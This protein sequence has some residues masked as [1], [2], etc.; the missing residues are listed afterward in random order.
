MLLVIENRKTTNRN[1][2]WSAS[3]LVLVAALVA[4]PFWDT[5]TVGQN[6]WQNPVTPFDV[7]DDTF[8]TPDDF[9]VESNA[10]RAG[11]ILTLPADAPPYY[12]VSGDMPEP[13]L[14]PLDLLLMVNEAAVGSDFIAGPPPGA[15]SPPIGPMQIRYDITDAAASPLSMV[16]VGA[17]FL[18]NAYVLDTRSGPLGVFGAYVDVVFDDQLA[19]IAGAALHGTDFESFPN[20][21]L[22]VA[23]GIKDVGSITSS[24]F[25][26]LSSSELLFFSLPMVAAAP[27]QVVFGGIDNYSM[28]IGLDDPLTADVVSASLTI[29]PEPTWPEPTWL[30]LW[31]GLIAG[32]ARASFVVAERQTQTL[33]NVGG[34]F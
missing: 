8:F 9:L 18:L 29:V 19:T 7:N 11:R 1:M 26:P 13:F 6:P 16:N 4:N 27:G 14:S 5:A 23:G 17:D 12:D 25:D 28:L 20:D 34:I 2:T 15:A 31:L 3:Q 32:T 30:V 33:E 10:I 24:L 22:V 21:G